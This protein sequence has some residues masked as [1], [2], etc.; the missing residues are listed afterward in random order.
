[1]CLIGARFSQVPQ[2]VTLGG[3]AGRRVKSCHRA[4]QCCRIRGHAVDVGQQ[5]S[6]GVSVFSCCLAGENGFDKI[7]YANR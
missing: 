7:L 4:G 3:E 6:S 1:M 5:V 2:E